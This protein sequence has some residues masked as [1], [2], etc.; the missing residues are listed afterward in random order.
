MR[1]SL[2]TLLI[3]DSIFVLAYVVLDLKFT[4]LVGLALE[5][6]LTPALTLTVG[7]RHFRESTVLSICIYVFAVRDPELYMSHILTVGCST[8]SLLPNQSIF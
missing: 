3:H 7:L 8:I 5:L 1:D 2:L 6:K 4:A